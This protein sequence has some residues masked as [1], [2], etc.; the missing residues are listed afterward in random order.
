M[1]QRYQSGVMAIS[2][3]PT[4]IAHNLT[5][6]TPVEYG[7]ALHSLTAIYFAGVSSTN[8]VV[9]VGGLG[10]AGAN[11]NIFCSIPHTVIQ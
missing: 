6:G 5:G 3:A 7:V 2:Q 11:A 9:A 4:V 1:A 10:G 8:V